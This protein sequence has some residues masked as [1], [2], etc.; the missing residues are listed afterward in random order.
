MN[1]ISTILLCV[2]GAF[3]LAAAAALIV[4]LIKL[5]KGEY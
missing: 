1:V 2:F 3:Y 4:L 5:I